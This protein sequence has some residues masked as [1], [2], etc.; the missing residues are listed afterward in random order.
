MSK[1][2]VPD[3]PRGKM[4]FFIWNNLPRFV[5]LALIALIIILVGA[6]R[7]K[8]QLI[9]A[10]KAAEGVQ[11]KP[12]VNA[13]ALILVPTTVTD[14]INLPGS[15]EPWTRLPLMAKLNGTVTEVLVGEG[16]RVKKGD[17]LA[18]IE[19]DDFRIALD[20]AEA[21]YNLSKAEYTRDKSIYDQGVIATATMDTNRTNVQKAKAD[22]ENARLL[23]S[24]TTVT[25]PM[26]GI[27][28]RLDAKVG[29][30]LSVGDPIAEILE[31]D[32]MKGVIGIPESDV[33][34]VRRLENV[35]LTIQALG[36]RI[37]TG[38]KHFLSP[39]P[40]STARI[41]QL[42]LEIDNGDGE[43]LAGMF[44]RADVVKKRI[45]NT[46]AVPFYSVISRNDEQYV[47]IEEDGVA[48]KRPVTL[49]TMEKWMVQITAGLSPGDR[50]L[51]EGHRDVEDNQQ[52]KIIKTLTDPA[53]L[54]L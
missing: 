48:R 22:Y 52:V 18:R 4:V 42:E 32:R 10:S 38:R 50:I 20:R 3:T 15:L 47:F 28:R 49:G 26:D 6:I 9:A 16:D 34:A 29:L 37:I 51:I 27:I 25:S 43:M 39:S 8:N 13:V 46:L 31:I 35:D 21:A 30:Q 14:R 19:D 17:T 23:L 36:D 33:S 45:D 44:V 40:E 53:E 12:P 41:Y 1:P 54:T 24:R 11:E 5:L 7:D 2:T